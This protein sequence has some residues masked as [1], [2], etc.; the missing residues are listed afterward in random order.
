MKALLRSFWFWAAVAM[1]LLAFAIFYEG[2]V[3]AAWVKLT[4]G[5]PGAP[6]AANTEQTGLSTWY[7]AN[8]TSAKTNAPASPSESPTS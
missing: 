7:E 8:V 2:R 4:G 1:A 5:T 6:F 3:R